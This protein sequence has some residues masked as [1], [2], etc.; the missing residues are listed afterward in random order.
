LK[1]VKYLLKQGADLQA[2]ADQA[3]RS[4]ARNGH[5]EVVKYL[6]ERGADLHSFGDYA[7]RCAAK[8]GYLEVVKYLVERGADPDKISSEILIK[9]LTSYSV[10]IGKITPRLLSLFLKIKLVK[11]A[12]KISARN[13]ILSAYKEKIVSSLVILMYHLYY[14]PRG[15]GFFQ[16]VEQI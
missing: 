3:L 7:I 15:P 9:L 16:A 11:K 8:N 13:R 2:G 14:R 10:Q 4:A 5:L 6:L 12:Y 1:V